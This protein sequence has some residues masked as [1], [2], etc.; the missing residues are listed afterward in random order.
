MRKSSYEIQADEFLEKTKTTMTV[1]YSGHGKYF[2]DDKD[3]R[4]IYTI[5]LSRPGKTPYTFTFGQSI[6]NSR[7]GTREKISYADRQKRR[8]KKPSAYDVLACLEKYE[9]DTHED[10]CAAFGY[11]TD[12]RK[13]LDL[14][15]RL[16]KEQKAV[17]HLFSDVMDELQ[18]IQ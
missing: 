16:Q 3:E 1:V 6:I 12:S 8:P 4:D 18:E 17:Y 5:T 7:P 2:P 10:F 14:Y 13:G 11:D 15:L 9:L